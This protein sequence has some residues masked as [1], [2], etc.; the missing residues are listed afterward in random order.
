MSIQIKFE[1]IDAEIQY[2]AELLCTVKPSSSQFE[3]DPENIICYNI[4]MFSKSLYIP[5][6]I[7]SNFFDSFPNDF[8]SSG[9]PRVF[10]PTNFQ[11]KKVPFKI[12]TDP[13]KYRDQD[14]VLKS[15]LEKL[16]T[17]RSVFLELATGF[18][19]TTMGNIL[20]SLLKVKTC[21]ICHLDIVLEQWVSEFENF[22][23]ATGS[24]TGS[25]AGG[26][27]AK[28]QR[29]K[30]KKIDPEADVYVIG[31]RKLANMERSDPDFARWFN[32]I[33][34]VIID[35]A[36][37]ATITA[38]TQSLLK[39]KPKYIIGMSATRKRAD[40]LHKLLNLYFGEDSN[41]IKRS[42]TKEFK[43]IKVETN[44]VPTIEYTH[45]QG[46]LVI[47]WTKLVNSLAY[48]EERHAL[49]ANIAMS[50][51][52][53]CILILSDRVEQSR[54]LHDILK[55]KG[56][57]VALLVETTKVWDKTCRILVAGTKKA[58]V[59]F[60]DPRLTMLIMMSDTKKVEQFEGRIRCSNN[61]I[62][63]IVDK[64][65]TLE[66]HWQLRKKWYLQRGATIEVQDSYLYETQ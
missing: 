28:V 54:S 62:Y 1:D 8:D 14:V 39:F 25:T 36:H 20:S 56:E 44:F 27:S 30:G 4:D 40:G 60:D 53:E 3:K 41:F 34:L 17:S 55:A 46:D 45:V 12:Q 35:E 2:A 61:I 23:T 65:P 50:H 18:G 37:I 15:A 52:N 42:E 32:S 47:N 22:T 63:D 48:N 7:W 13:K 6:G 11:T 49:V 9:K 64:N 16:N 57:S 10:P 59:G 31:I 5:M 43:V 26:K 21:V 19:K 51:P 66:R 29:V 58:G 33:G 24:G 38:F